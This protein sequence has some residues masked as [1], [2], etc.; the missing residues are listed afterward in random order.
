[1]GGK[2]EKKEKTQKKTERVWR[3]KED[4]RFANAGASKRYQNG[5]GARGRNKNTEIKKIAMSE[6]G[7]KG[8]G[9]KREESCDQ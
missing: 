3:D 7:A 2:I 8:R 1:V 6:T 5:C 9:R 4:Y